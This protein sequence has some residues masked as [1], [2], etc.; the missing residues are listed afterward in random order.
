MDHIGIDV[1]KRDSQICILVEGGEIIERRCRTERSRF[2]ELLGKRPRARIVIEASTES[3]W[4]AQCLESLGHEV[5][6]ADPNF[7]SMYATRSRKVKT[8][9]RDARTLAEACRL[10]AYRAAHRTS[11]AQR[12]VRARL[13]VREVLVRT[14]TRSIAL[15]GALLRQRGWRIATGTADKF[16]AR[17][18]RLELPGRLRSEVAPLC[19]LILHANRQI[20]FLDQVIEDVGRRDPAV[21][22]LRSMPS[23]GP[24]TAAAFVATLDQDARRFRSAHQVESYLGLVPRERSSGEVQRK[25]SITKA[26]NRRMRWLLVQAAVSTLRL[27]KP[28]TAA[29]WLWAERMAV[30]RGKKI[31]VVALARR[32]AGVLYAMMRDQSIYRPSPLCR[33]ADLPQLIAQAT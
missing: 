19:A 22:R 16:V 31:A 10:G 11:E 32:L 6:V 3:E 33:V 5:V 29:L 27:K 1:H 24:V 23:I 7:A 15:M 18:E 21:R 8:D 9:R 26:G 30:R 17:V 2:E 4:V 13:A 20:Q 14:R 25:G 28:E 12:H